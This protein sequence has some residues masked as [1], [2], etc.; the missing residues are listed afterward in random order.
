MTSE[1]RVR[2]RVREKERKEKKTIQTVVIEYVND[3]F[4]INQSFSRFLARFSA[5]AVCK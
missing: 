4:Q 1:F 3:L 5:L 2:K